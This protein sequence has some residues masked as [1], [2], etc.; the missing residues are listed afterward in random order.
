[1]CVCTRG[2]CEVEGP[3][4]LD[5]KADLWSAIGIGL[6][7]EPAYTRR[8]SPA[9]PV[10]EVALGPVLK[11]LGPARADRG[12][13]PRKVQKRRG[14]HTA[15]L[16]DGQVSSRGLAGVGAGAGGV[17]PGVRACIPGCLGPSAVRSLLPPRFL[18]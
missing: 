9:V 2:V 8:V 13:L 11:V 5:G 15:G 17:A 7:G 14:P 6:D 18:L 3:E 10:G 12:A 16:R 4:A 1:M